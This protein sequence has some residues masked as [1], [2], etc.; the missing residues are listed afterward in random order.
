MAK[1]KTLEDLFHDTLKDINYAERKILKALPDM[2]EKG[3]KTPPDG[4][5]GPP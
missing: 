1:E 2:A 4:C 3:H 5:Q